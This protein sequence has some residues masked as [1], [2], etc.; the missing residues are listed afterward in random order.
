MSHVALVLTGVNRIFADPAD[1]AVQQEILPAMLIGIAHHFHE[2]ALLHEIDAH[3][4]L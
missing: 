4:N 2:H 3:G 1:D